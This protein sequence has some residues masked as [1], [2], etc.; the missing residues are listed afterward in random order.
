MN[1]RHYLEYSIDKAAI[2]NAAD[3]ETALHAL[4]RIEGRKMFTPDK[5][6]GAVM[7]AQINIVHG[8][9]LMQSFYYPLYREQVIA[10]HGPIPGRPG[11]SPM[12]P[13]RPKNAARERARDPGG[14][15]FRLFIGEPCVRCG[16]E[17]R[18]SIGLACVQCCLR[19]SR[20]QT[21]A[22]RAKRH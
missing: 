18:Y 11:R 14:R 7:H 10:E 12:R 16:N 2:E 5:I 19:R 4:G 22:K 9:R 8:Q 20:A 3:L 15:L 1:T 17:V 6:S 21:A 13:G